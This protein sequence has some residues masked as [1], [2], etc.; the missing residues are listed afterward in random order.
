[1]ISGD[2]QRDLSRKTSRL[3]LGRLLLILI[4]CIW[5]QSCS[6]KSE[7]LVITKTEYLYPSAQYLLP[8]KVPSIDAFSRNNG[9]L[10]EAYLIV[11]RALNSA[12]DD[13]AA[14]REEIEKHKLLEKAD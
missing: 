1:M 10:A 3:Y 2:K 14:I 12:N 4:L 6:N 13:K 9:G 11:R 5:L 7:I 8:T